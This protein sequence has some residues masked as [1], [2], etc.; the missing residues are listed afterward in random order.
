MTLKEKILISLNIFFKIDLDNREISK[1]RNSYKEREELG[2]N[3]TNLFDKLENSYSSD[4]GM[5]LAL[6]KVIYPIKTQ[7]LKREVIT[8]EQK[9]FLLIIEERV[10]TENNLDQLSAGQAPTIKL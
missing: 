1:L 6:D 2:L 4:K 5:R 7:E 8:Q 9:R 10:Y 3:L